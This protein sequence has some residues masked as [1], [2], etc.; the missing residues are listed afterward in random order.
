[1]H[2]PAAPPRDDR[3]LLLIVEDEAAIAEAMAELLDDAGF[4]IKLA[5]NGAEALSLL[6]EHVVGAIVDVMMPVMD[7]INFVLLLRSDPSFAR[8]PVI[9][10]SAALYDQTPLAGEVFLPKPFTAEQLFAA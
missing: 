6:D 1:M 7:G 3:P 2:A 9:M 10:T 5:G 4:D 8:L